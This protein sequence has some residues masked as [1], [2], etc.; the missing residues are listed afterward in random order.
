MVENRSCDKHLID[1][2]SLEDLT[3]AHSDAPL[4]CLCPSPSL[5]FL[6]LPPS[7]GHLVRCSTKS[8]FSRLRN[9]FISSFKA[10]CLCKKRLTYNQEDHSTHFFQ[11]KDKHTDIYTHSQSPLFV[12]L[13]SSCP[14]SRTWFFSTIKNRPQQ[15]SNLSTKEKQ[16]WCQ[17]ILRPLLS[18]VQFLPEDFPFIQ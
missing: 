10:L 14:G 17:N 16:K 9:V 11:T 12:L 18:T 2:V 5:S 4:S 15:G 7:P 3:S 6:L 13:S 1:P 8:V